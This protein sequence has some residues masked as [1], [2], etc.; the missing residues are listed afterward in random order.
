TVMDRL[1][2]E[3]SYDACEKADSSLVIDAADVQKHLGALF[4]DEDLSSFIV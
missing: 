1:M 3:I 2:E 4:E